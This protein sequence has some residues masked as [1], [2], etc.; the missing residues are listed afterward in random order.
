MHTIIFNMSLRLIPSDR[1]MAVVTLGMLLM[2]SLA[3]K[4]TDNNFWKSTLSSNNVNAFGDE[5]SYNLIFVT[6]GIVDIWLGEIIKR[7][8]VFCAELRFI[9]S[10][11]DGRILFVV[12]QSFCTKSNIPFLTLPI[13]VAMLTYMNL[14]GDGMLLVWRILQTKWNCIIIVTTSTIAHLLRLSDPTRS[15]MSRVM[16]EQK[17][18]VGHGFAWSYYFGYLRLIIPGLQSRMESWKKDIDTTRKC[19]VV[20]KLYILIPKSCYC[21]PSITA[22]DPQLKVAGVTPSFV[23]NRAG[24]QRREYKN[25]V[26]CFESDKTDYYC[27]VEYATPI[28]SLYEMSNSE[29]AGLSSFER[30]QQMRT[31][32]ATLQDI[33][34]SNPETKNNCSLLVYD[35]KK[36]GDGQQSITMLI[37]DRIEKDLSE[38]AVTKTF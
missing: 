32:V 27:L 8:F 3:C 28:L 23:A 14:H 2:F 35:D 16:E 24:N 9:N 29:E 4:S 22:A 6:L 15:E 19:V 21:P 26:Y 1:A 13:L 33:I 30:L 11:Y 18:N 12:Q 34:N 5:L 10:R 36:F 7:V 17:L 20:P 37:K 25:T 31:F 38:K